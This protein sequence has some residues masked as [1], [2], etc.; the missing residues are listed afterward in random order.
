MMPLSDADRDRIRSLTIDND[1]NR[2]LA[3]ER[4]R[5]L[6]DNLIDAAELIEGVR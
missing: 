3:S 4:A 6:H 1:A 2:D 5:Q